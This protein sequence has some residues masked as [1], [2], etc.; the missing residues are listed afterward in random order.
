MIDSNLLR[1]GS[2]NIRLSSSAYEVLIEDCFKYGF[3]KNDKPNIS[4]ILSRLAKELTEYRLDLHEELLKNNENDEKVVR[5]IETNI[6][7]IYHKKLNYICDDSYVDVGYRP[8]KEFKNC[9]SYIFYEILEKF[10]MDF[11]SYIKSIVH[12]Y[13][14][15]TES[16]RELFLFYSLVK[17]IKKA[18]KQ[19]RIVKIVN[20]G[21]EDFVVVIAIEQNNYGYNYMLCLTSDRERCLFLPIGKTENF[22]IT[23]DKMVISG[24]DYNKILSY[25][26]TF[27]EENEQCLAQAVI[28]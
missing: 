15:R 27:L 8:N 1:G 11:A 2:T 12:E 9:I 22:L 25:F 14:S 17:K 18:I 23:K 16:Q 13:S 10:D 21:I 24:E 20:E 19:E 4:Y 28:K 3:V 26:D 7:N 6:F 5:N